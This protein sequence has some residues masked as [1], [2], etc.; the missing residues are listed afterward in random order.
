MR[1]IR[2]HVTAAEKK[3]IA[4]L[5]RAG[6]R[7]SVIARTLGIGAPSVSKVQ[8]EAGLPT[9]LIVPEAKILKLFTRGWGGYKISKHLHVP[10][11]QVYRVA[12]K[13]NFRRADGIGYPE[14][15][16]DVAGFIEAVKR[17]DGYIKVLARKYGVGFCQARRIALEIRGVPEFR[18]GLAKP[19]LSSNFPQKHFRKKIGEHGGGG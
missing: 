2:W 12:H 13:N 8:R 3:E 14:P 16:G 10:A 6:I 9:R 1:K 15:H 19:P 11:N 5:T 7:Q 18:R 17:G 4:R